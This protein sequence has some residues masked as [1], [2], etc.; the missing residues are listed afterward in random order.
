MLEDVSD[1]RNLLPLLTTRIACG[2]KA[3]FGCLFIS[4]KLP[5]NRPG[6][7]RAFFIPGQ[8]YKAAKIHLAW[9]NYT[10]LRLAFM[11]WVYGPGLDTLHTRPSALRLH[12]PP[13]ANLTY[14]KTLDEAHYSKLVFVHA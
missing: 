1:D 3:L 5:K 9:K 7:M 12:I 2:T 13:D 10:T 4:G 11:H 14:P 6:R 8:H